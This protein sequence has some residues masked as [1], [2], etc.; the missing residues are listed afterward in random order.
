MTF[1]HP[2]ERQKHK[3][4]KR[5]TTEIFL[6]TRLSNIRPGM[7]SVRERV[8]W[9]PAQ[10]CLHVVKREH[11]STPTL[12]VPATAEHLYHIVQPLDANDLNKGYKTDL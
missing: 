1:F 2:S 11:Q 10:P 3:T 5:H 9:Q 6:L 4:K 7:A 8:A 12:I